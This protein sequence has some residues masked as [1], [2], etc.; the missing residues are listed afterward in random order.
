MTGRHVAVI[1]AGPAG[2]TAAYQLALD[3]IKVT[4]FE[5]EGTVGGM[6]KT[7]PLWGQLVDLGP[8]RFFTND[9][10]VNAVWM[11]VIGREFGIIARLTRIYYRD[12]FFDYPLKAF[13]ALR[14]LGAA[15]VALCVLS[16]L[17]ARMFPEKDETTFESWVS[18]RFG[19][20]LFRTF[21][22]SYTEKLW[23]FSCRE[24][25]SDFAAQR[26][27]KLSLFEAVRSAV[28]GTGGARHKSLVDEFAYPLGGAGE[29]YTRMADLIRD[30]GGE[31]C[32][33]APVASVRPADLADAPVFLTFPDGS[34]RAFDHVVSTMPITTLVERMDAPQAIRSHVK[35]LRFRNTILVFLRVQ[36]E[37]PFPDQWIYVHSPGLRAGRIT[38]FRNWVPQITRGMPDT[39]LCLEYWCFDED[40]IWSSDEQSLIA[41]A[42]E[43]MFR[44][45]LI[46]GR[47][48]IDGKVVRIPRSY[49]VYS[50][51]YRRHLAPVERYLSTRKNLSVIGRAGSFKYN[52]QDHSILMGLLA[53]ENIAK[54][55]AHDLW[56]I[57]SD[58]EYQE[59][60]TLVG[61]DS[62]QNPTAD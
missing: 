19:K 7:I 20:R 4:V 52:N 43:E 33:G 6:A 34:E 28:F 60:V 9:P 2:L 40:A 12:T 10:R 35:A 17:N 38:N 37:S 22:N 8:H 45:S 62:R 47:T 49:P 46:P 1:G 53:A 15:E 31:I 50:S 56:G 11:D 32:L 42:T 16:Y 14:G 54:G 5:A 59:T 29:L 27:K 39:I 55:T 51:G 21:F 24:L 58:D 23:G 57:N 41:M 36:G 26:I 18:N 13:N 3:G 30:A 44:T 48:V 25:D 61:K